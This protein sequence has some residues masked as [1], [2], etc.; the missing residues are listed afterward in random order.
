MLFE[1]WVEA[2]GLSDHILEGHADLYQRWMLCS[3]PGM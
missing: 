1:G 3:M 2:D